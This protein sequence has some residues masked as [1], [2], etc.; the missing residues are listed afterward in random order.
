MPS[1]EALSGE[2]PRTDSYTSTLLKSTMQLW[3][4]TC[5]GCLTVALEDGRTRLLQT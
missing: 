1:G 3:N 5:L 2:C 4:D